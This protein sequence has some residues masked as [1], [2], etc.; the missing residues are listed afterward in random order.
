MLTVFTEENDKEVFL[1]GFD[2]ISQKS[3][4]ADCLNLYP[5]STRNDNFSGYCLW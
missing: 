5:I 4:N 3:I 2:E 1:F